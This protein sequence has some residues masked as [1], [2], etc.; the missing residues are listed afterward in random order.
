VV[1]LS[2]YILVDFYA[3][4]HRSRNA[5]HRAGKDF[6]SPTGI[7]TTGI[8]STIRSITSF[9]K[10]HPGEVIICADS[11]VSKR[12][13]EEG[14]YKG[15]RE[16]KEESF[17]LEAKE[18]LNLLRHLYS[19]V[20]VEGFEADDIIS[21]LLDC[22]P[23]GSVFTILTCDKDLLQ[24][25]SPTVTVELFNSSRKWKTYTPNEV[26]EEYGISHP[27]HLALL[28]ALSGDSSD[29]IKGLARVGDKTA[30]KEIYEA[31]Q[32][33]GAVNFTALQ[34]F[35]EG[36]EEGGGERFRR[37]LSLVLPLDPGLSFPHP[38]KR[39]LGALTSRL[40]FL[41]IDPC[42]LGKTV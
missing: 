42:H 24:H 27:W 19:I 30:A 20:S 9:A 10:K 26:M 5:L 28:K 25:C 16:K 38:P 14:S 29:N 21:G 2:N 11:G 36:R 8:F 37:N 32:P 7:P 13:G 6:R 12:K 18:T 3:V 41:G 34:R 17:Y 23:E 31:V 33:D 1:D 15:N 22:A 40:E 39:D 35:A 4:F